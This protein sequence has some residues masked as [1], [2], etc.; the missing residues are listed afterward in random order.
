[1]TLKASRKILLIYDDLLFVSIMIDMLTEL[2]HDVEFADDA[3]TGLLKLK[4]YH[5][6]LVVLDSAVPGVDGAA[7]I[8]RLRAAMTGSI[9]TAIFLADGA[10]PA[11]GGSKFKGAAVTKLLEKPLEGK[12]LAELIQVHFGQTKRPVLQA[13]AKFK[14]YYNREPY[15]P[16]IASPLGKIRLWGTRGST[17][18]SRPE[19]MRHGGNTSCIEISCGDDLLIFDAGTGIREL[20]NLLAQQGPRK[21][22][23]FFTHTH[24]D[25]IQGFPFFVP[26]FIP[27]FDLTIYGASGMNVDL[28]SIFAGQQ[29]REYFPVALDTLGAKI[30][31]VEVALNARVRIGDVEVSWEHTH[32]P[33]ATVAYKVEGKGKSIVYLGDNEFLTGY[34]GR[35]HDITYDTFVVASHRKLIDFLSGVDLL[36]G[37]SQYESE[38][39]RKKIGWGHTSVPNGCL[40]AK[41]SQVKKWIVTHHDPTHDDDRLQ[42]KLALTRQILKEIQH[43]IEVVHAFDTMVEHV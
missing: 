20:G 39:Y 5:P 26:A 21:I 37:E 41:L 16:R 27:G 1:M 23:L 43:P 22:H 13:F 34:L 30:K 19:Y 25:H 3:E 11:A 35:P 24:W 9:E 28:K 2:G 7:Y 6:D 17:P 36:I 15:L 12:V 40:L 33:G 38:E 8:T 4:A 29:N 42:N 31:F 18:I 10:K 14:E 32:H